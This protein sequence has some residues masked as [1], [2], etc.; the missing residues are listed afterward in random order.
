MQIINKFFYR[1]LVTQVINSSY[2][3][4]D[5]LYS[6]YLRATHGDSLYIKRE[7]M[8]NDY[9]VPEASKTPKEKVNLINYY[10]IPGS[11]SNIYFSL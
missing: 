9:I 11:I 10:K 4:W 1:R 5:Y 6:M 8:I 3:F 7:G 2:E